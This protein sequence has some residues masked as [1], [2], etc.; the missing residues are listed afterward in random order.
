MTIKNRWHLLGGGVYV[1]ES[2]G[3]LILSSEGVSKTNM[4]ILEDFVIDALLDYIKKVIK[5]EK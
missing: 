2:K 4:V 5:K 1:A 3:Y